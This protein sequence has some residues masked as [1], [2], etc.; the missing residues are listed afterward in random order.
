MFALPGQ[1]QDQWEQTVQGVLEL[2]P[3][4][5]SCYSLI[6]EEETP[7]GDAYARGN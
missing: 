7:F 5:L 2:G 6:I 4:H 3:D 1:T